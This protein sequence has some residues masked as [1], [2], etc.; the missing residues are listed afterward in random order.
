MEIDCNFGLLTMNQIRVEIRLLHVLGLYIYIRCVCV[1][2]FDSLTHLSGNVI[3]AVTSLV[4]SVGSTGWLA[5][6]D[7]FMLRFQLGAIPGRSRREKPLT[8]LLPR[9][10]NAA[11]LELC[12]LSLS[13]SSSVCVWLIGAHREITSVS[14]CSTSLSP[15]LA[16]NSLA[17][18]C[19]P[20][21]F[22]WHSN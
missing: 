19:S 3:I 4:V 20:Q 18:E 1:H 16:T 5:G 15:N 9:C 8:N 13:L 6:I 14:C 10:C 2:G 22:K 12:T 21:A 11:P 17:H 7:F